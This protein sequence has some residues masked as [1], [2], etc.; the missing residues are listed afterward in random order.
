MS[1]GEAWRQVIAMAEI[2]LSEGEAADDIVGYVFAINGKIDGGDGYASNVLFRKMWRKQLAANVTEGNGKK[3]AA[4]AAAPR[5]FR[6]RRRRPT[7]AGRRIP[8]RAPPR[9]RRPPRAL[10]ETALQSPWT[11]YV[12]S[13]QLPAPRFQLT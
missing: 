8:A 1:A 4:G 6:A 3:G 11:D 9:G 12:R 13:F 10:R 5:A 2:Q 7:G